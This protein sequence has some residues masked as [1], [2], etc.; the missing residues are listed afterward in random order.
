MGGGKGRGKKLFVRLENK[1]FPLTCILYSLSHPQKNF[2]LE[3]ISP[4]FSTLSGYWIVTRPPGSGS[5]LQG[6]TVHSGLH[7][8]RV[9]FPPTNAY[10]WNTCIRYRCEQSSN[11]CPISLNAHFF[12]KHKNDKTSKVFDPSI[13]AVTNNVPIKR[14]IS[15]YIPISGH[16]KVITAGNEVRGHMPFC[17]DRVKLT[18]MIL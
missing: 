3:P 5:S 4:T 6:A 9:N 17:N 8:G 2:P 16:L 10:Q 12:T 13:Q 1:R 15:R 14:A 18:A 7:N 11:P